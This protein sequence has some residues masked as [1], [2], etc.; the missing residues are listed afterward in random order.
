MDFEE[1][2]FPIFDPILLDPILMGQE[3]IQVPISADDIIHFE[4]LIQ[5]YE[6]QQM[7][8]NQIGYG[9]VPFRIEQRSTRHNE[10]F[11]CVE[12][13]FNLRFDNSD[14]LF[15]QAIDQ[16]RELFETLFQM[17][18]DPLHNEDRIRFVFFHDEIALPIAFP[19]MFKPDL[20]VDHILSYF[21]IVAQSHKSIPINNNNNLR[22]HMTIASVPRGGNFDP[23]QNYCNKMTSVKVIENTD[24]LCALRA[25]ITGKMF[26][27]DPESMTN[28]KFRNKL[29]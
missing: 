23:L 11:N 14:T 10:K 20:S 19:F 6:E 28:Y 22:A 21:E 15:P 16:L 25:I 27:D 3:I 17:H 18:I 5:E 1:E 2:F 24:G 29:D 7:E 12:K 26:Y 4:H 13:T 8:V 9:L